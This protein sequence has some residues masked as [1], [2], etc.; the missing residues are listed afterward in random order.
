MDNDNPYSTHFCG[1]WRSGKPKLIVL[2][3]EF[4]WRT[5]DQASRYNEFYS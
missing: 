1:G 2:M 4:A 3:A 5:T